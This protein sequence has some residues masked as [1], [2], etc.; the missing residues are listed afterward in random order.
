M[1]HDV[2]CVLSLFGF[3]GANLVPEGALSLHII[4]ITLVAGH[5]QLFTTDLLFTMNRTFSIDLAEQKLKVAS[6]GRLVF[7]GILTSAERL[8]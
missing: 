5:Q 7:V 6:L 3:V 2:E 8:K 1:L 4:T